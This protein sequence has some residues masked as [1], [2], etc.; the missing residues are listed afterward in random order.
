M[1]RRGN[2]FKLPESVIR[3]PPFPN[4]ISL[5]NSCFALLVTMAFIKVALLL[6][7]SMGFQVALMEEN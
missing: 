1:Y 6:L 7:F 3:N 4:F 5:A 2:L